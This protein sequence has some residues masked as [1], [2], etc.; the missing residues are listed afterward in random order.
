[1]SDPVIPYRVSYSERVRQWL[2]KLAGEAKQRGDGVQFA[3]ALKEFHRMLGLYPQFGEPFIDLTAEPGQIYMGIIRP[4][5]MRYVVDEQRRLVM[6]GDLPVLLPMP[7][8]GE[9]PEKE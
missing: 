1:V 2:R 3:D 9:E 5:A 6:V 7:S 8:Q 4:L